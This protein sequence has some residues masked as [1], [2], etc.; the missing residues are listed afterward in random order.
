VSYLSAPD[1]SVKSACSSHIDFVIDFVRTPYA[2]HSS[3]VT[4]LK[5][6]PLLTS[7]FCFPSII[8]EREE[9]DAR[10][11]DIPVCVERNGNMIACTCTGLSDAS[12]G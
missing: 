1:L 8:F 9:S 6:F 4:Y 3:S 12:W 10:G 7:Q 5:K 2:V 11:A